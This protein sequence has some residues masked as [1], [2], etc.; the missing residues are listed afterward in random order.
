VGYR[1][2]RLFIFLIV[3]LTTRLELH[4]RERVPTSGASIV[5][6]NHLGRLDPLLVYYILERRDII[7]LVAEKYRKYAPARWF[8]RQLGALWIERYNA[9]FSALRQTLKLLRQGSVLV[10]APEGTR[11]KT[12]ALIEARPGASYLA[13]K[14]GLPILPVGI[15]GTEDRMVRASLLRLRRP[16]VVI[17]AG[18]PFTL[19]PLKGDDRDAQLKEYTDEIM[20]RIA[21]LLPAEYRG[22]YADHPRLKEFLEPEGN[23]AVEGQTR[24]EG[25]P[26]GL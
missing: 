5:V 20:C 3:R 14:A 22:V 2:A 24:L 12:G 15:T 10:L 19:P 7:L 18:E 4:G 1:L 13:V 23:H 6:A 17:R 21:A 8:V 26:S 25:A 9:D 11:S 16:H